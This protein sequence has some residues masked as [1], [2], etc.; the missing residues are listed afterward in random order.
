MDSAAE[1]GNNN[2]RGFLV[3]ELAKFPEKTIVDEGKLASI[4]KIT[5]RTLRRMVLRAE[6]PPP[7]SLGGRSI[8][9]SDR[10]LVYL[11]AAAELAEKES[12]NQIKRIS[13]YSP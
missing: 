13:K 1:T 6:L 7:I 5:P 9:L 8:W 4:L 12:L 3:D 11:N 10:I 2:E